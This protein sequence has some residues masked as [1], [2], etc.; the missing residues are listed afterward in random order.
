MEDATGDGVIRFVARVSSRTPTSGNDISVTVYR[1]RK[2]D[3]VVKNTI[4]I[5][6]RKKKL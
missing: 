6:K 1:V 4:K 2:P 3:L 5:C